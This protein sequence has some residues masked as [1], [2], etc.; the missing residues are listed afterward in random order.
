MT[1]RSLTE[2]NSTYKYIVIL[3]AGY[4]GLTAALRLSR[5]FRKHY[6]FKIH[7]IDKNPYHTLK[8]QLHEAAVHKNEVT[9]PIERIV[10]NK[11]ITFHK[12]LI[13]KIDLVSRKIFLDDEIISFAYLIIALGSKS[14][15]YNIEGLSDYSFPLQ[16]YDDA[17]NINKHLSEICSKASL[18][19][20]ESKRKEELTFVVGGGGLSG[21]EFVA[22]LSDQVRQCLENNNINEN[23]FNV[24]LVEAAEKILPGVSPNIRE[25]IESKLQAKNIH[26]LTK[27]KIIKVTNDEVF[28]SNSNS[29]KCKT[30]VWTGG[31]RTSNLIKKSGFKTGAAGRIIVDEFLRAREY[32]FVFALGDNALAINPV[33]GL[34]VPTAAQFALQQGRLV[35]QNIFNEVYAQQL[36]AYKPRVWGEF[37]SLGKH[38]AA[39]WLA[40][41]FSRKV[42][43]IGFLANLINTAIKEKHIFILRKES[44]KWITY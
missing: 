44:R 29:L 12:G 43:F 16:S 21:V 1:N 26:L 36:I 19:I 17:E 4:G 10:S 42:S 23:G 41:P 3:G 22:E 34:P 37:I 6:N 40:L 32:P 28:F 30:L 7:L 38:L 13:K 2:M 20:D 11:N 8:T 35:A 9:I 18:E 5:L 39:G 14:N 31:I 15:F 24:F 25:R 33:S 27:T